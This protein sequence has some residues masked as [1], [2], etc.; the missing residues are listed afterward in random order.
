MAPRRTCS[1]TTHPASQRPP[2][3]PPPLAS[4]PPCTGTE[5]SQR[6]RR[7]RSS[8]SSGRRRSPVSL[9]LLANATAVTANRGC[10]RDL[11]QRE[12]RRQERR[13]FEEEPCA[14]PGHLLLPHPW[15]VAA[16]AY[17][18]AFPKRKI[19]DG[20]GGVPFEAPLSRRLGRLVLTKFSKGD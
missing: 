5:K 7:T 3:P 16:A 6:R 12:R 13:L 1:T 19:V 15:L 17:G 9:S 20:T 8:P 10:L 11:R 14:L 2:P 18:G 4:L